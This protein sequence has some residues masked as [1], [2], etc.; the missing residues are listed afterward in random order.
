MS[1]TNEEREKI[2]AKIRAL[3]NMA[4]PENGAYE[5]E[6]ETA[7][8]AMQRLMDQY[9][10]GLAEVMAASADGKG[11]L[12]FTT[13]VSSS[14][15]GSLKQ[16]H[17]GLGRVIS[18]ITGTK[19]FA[20]S[21]YGRTVRDPKGK[22]KN[23]HSMS[24]FGTEQTAKLATQ[25]FDVWVIDIDRMATKAV[26]D[27]MK[28]LKE[29]YADEMEASGIKDIRHM[30]LGNDHPNTYRDSWLAGVITGIDA[31]LWAAEKER[32]VETSTAI[33]LVSNAVEVAYKDRSRGFKHVNTS[34]VN[35]N[36]GAF[37]SGREVGK[38]INLT[39]KKIGG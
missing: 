8:K 5:Q 19:Y 24:F 36:F 12:E 14:L 11:S 23:G 6:I 39:S 15:I 25:L 37:A 16:W 2:L 31:A 33:V 34:R 17:W 7:S 29:Q 1:L 4:N 9:S 20:T 26:S 13:E 18:K 10:I 28:E 32:T 21:R 30:H 35:G 27:Y 3:A 22:E 38:G